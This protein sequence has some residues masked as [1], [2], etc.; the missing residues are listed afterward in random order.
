MGREGREA[1]WAVAEPSIAK[2]KQQQAMA[3]PYLATSLLTS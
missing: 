2:S 1:R 3:I